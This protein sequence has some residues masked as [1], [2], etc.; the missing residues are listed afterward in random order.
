MTTKRMI[1]AAAG[2]L[3]AAGPAGAVAGCGSTT[4]TTSAGWYQAGHSWGAK[5]RATGDNVAPAGFT[6]ADYCAAALD[7]ASLIPGNPLSDID[8]TG[9][10][11]IMPAPSPV[12]QSS[13]DAMSWINGC[14][15]GNTLPAPATS[16]PAA[17]PSTST[18][19]ATQTTVA[20]PTTSAPAPAAS[21]NPTVVAQIT[22]NWEAFFNSGTPVAKRVLLITNGQSLRVLLNE[23]AMAGPPPNGNGEYDFGA[24]VTSVTMNSATSATVTYNYILDGQTAQSG[25]TGTAADQNGTWKVSS[26]SYCAL[27]VSNDNGS[28]V[29][30]CTSPAA[31]VMPVF[32]CYINQNE[33][34]GGFFGA[35]IN[36]ISGGTGY[37]SAVV[38]VVILDKNG[39]ALQTQTVTAYSSTENWQVPIDPEGAPAGSSL[40]PDDEASCTATVESVS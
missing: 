38:K 14:A 5:E 18:V 7:R 37:S 10:G 13:S 2:I 34:G 40:N 20:A 11:T 16:A 30:G 12:P 35:S 26:V 39:N 36:I 8:W 6:E 24:M 17:A 1:T 25:L 33:G 31:A 19:P 32:G 27:L 21:S 22:A 28:P 9:P 23:E 3:L 29:A 15:T 4:P